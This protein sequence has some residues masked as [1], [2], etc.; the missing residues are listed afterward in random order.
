M[1]WSLHGRRRASALADRFFIGGGFATLLKK[2]AGVDLRG[3]MFEITILLLTVWL[4]SVCWGLVGGFFGDTSKCRGAFG[5]IG[6][7]NEDE[8]PL[9][10]RS[11]RRVVIQPSETWFLMLD[12][13]GL[14]S[15][16]WG[17][18]MLCMEQEDGCFEH[19]HKANADF[20]SEEHGG[21]KCASDLSLVS[22]M[23]LTAGAVAAGSPAR[24]HVFRA[25]LLRGPPWPHSARSNRIGSLA[26]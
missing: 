17:R 19:L 20:Y 24:W 22:S 16:K 2:S 4:F 21:G 11:L 13:I 14:N 18:W 23:F 15:G 8:Q 6:I 7:A 25:R 26:A 5:S 3:R 12:R 10:L 1:D 9:L